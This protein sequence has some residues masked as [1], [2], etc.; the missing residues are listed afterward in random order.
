MA[1]DLDKIKRKLQDSLSRGG[2][3]AFWKPEKDSTTQIRIVPVMDGSDDPFK[4]FHMH[5]NI[6]KAQAFLCPK[7]NYD[8]D[9]PVCNLATELWESGDKDNRNQA[10]DFFAKQRYYSPILVRGKEAEGVK[11]Y[12]YSKT[13]YEA[14]LKLV[15]NEDYGDI[16]D[17]DSGFDLLL[18][19]SQAAGKQYPDTMITA[20][21][22]QSGICDTGKKD[23]SGKKV[24]LAKKDC[25]KMLSEIPSIEELLDR[26]TSAEVK[27]IL[28]AAMQLDEPAAEQNSKELTT[29]KEASEPAG[30]KIDAAFNKLLPDDE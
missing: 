13:V 11:W 20:K 10:K 18:E 5:Y 24:M 12:G 8:E 4:Q 19:Y 15:L 14:F 28:D 21:R 26:K 22:L 17:P 3:K 27:A 2:N 23:D 6:G 25:Q 16:T 29:N 30:D 1:L 7:R 9:C